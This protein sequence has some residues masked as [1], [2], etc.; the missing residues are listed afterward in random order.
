MTISLE[1]FK[2]TATLAQLGSHDAEALLH[3]TNLILKQIY[4]IHKIDVTGVEPLI[5]SVEAFQFLREDT[6]IETQA[7][8]ALANAA[9]AFADNHYLVPKHLKG[10]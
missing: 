9:P 10:R 1:Q 5:H 8:D 6:A 4:N 3:E 7:V 2:K